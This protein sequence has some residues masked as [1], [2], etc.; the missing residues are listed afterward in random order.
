[1]LK[2]DR[3]VN[4]QSRIRKAEEAGLALLVGVGVPDRPW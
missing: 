4:F 3:V 1:L 2:G